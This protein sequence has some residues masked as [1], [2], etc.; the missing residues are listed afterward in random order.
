MVK[1]ESV[2]VVKGGKGERKLRCFGEW[3]GTELGGIGEWSGMG[4]SGVE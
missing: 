3:S 2:K 1:S 4:W